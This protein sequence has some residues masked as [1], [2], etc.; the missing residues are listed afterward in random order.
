MLSNKPTLQNIFNSDSKEEKNMKERKK[1]NSR[2]HIK[3]TWNDQLLWRTET[4]QEKN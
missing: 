3:Q 2:P 4:K 1:I